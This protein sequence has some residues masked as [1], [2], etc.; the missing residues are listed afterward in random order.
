MQRRDDRMRGGG[1]ADR[2]PE[3]M[4]PG[5]PIGIAGRAFVREV[6]GAWRA[7]R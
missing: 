3:R 2:P 7:K 1:V 5:Q 6:D 4:E